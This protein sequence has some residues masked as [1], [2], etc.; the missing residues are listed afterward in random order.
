MQRKQY[1]DIP[2]DDLSYLQS[3]GDQILSSTEDVKRSTSKSNNLMPS[4]EYKQRINLVD[5]SNIEIEDEDEDSGK[6]S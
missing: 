2:R 4:T 5:K 6:C 3:Q 1:S